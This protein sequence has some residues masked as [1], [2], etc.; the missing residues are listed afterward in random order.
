MQF[1][2]TERLVL[3]NTDV[4]DAEEMHDYRNDERCARYQRGQTKDRAGIVAL[5]ERHAQ[6]ILSADAPALIA[7]ARKETD[8][9]IG[10]I[11]VMPS[12][13]TISLGYTFSYKIHRRGYAYEALSALLAHLHGEYPAWDFISFTE[14]ENIPSRRLLEKLGYEDLGYLPSK[15]SEVFGKHLRPDTIA[16]LAGAMTAKEEKANEHMGSAI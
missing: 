16:E 9:L 1:L 11:V 4:R 15:D 7:V 14:R 5:L 12:E 2:E 6:D 3:R 10:E 13:G 8:Q